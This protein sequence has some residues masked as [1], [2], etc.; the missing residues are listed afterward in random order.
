MSRPPLK[1]LTELF[2]YSQTFKREILTRKWMMQR[3]SERWET[4]MLQFSTPAVR[5]LALGIMSKERAQ[6]QLL[7]GDVYF[8]E[9]NG[10]PS[11]REH[12]DRIGEVMRQVIGRQ[13]T[14]SQFEMPAQ[15][16]KRYIAWSP[17]DSTS[18]GKAAFKAEAEGITYE[19]CI[20]NAE[21]EIA[22]IKQGKVT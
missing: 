5:K 15:D 17:S 20:A 3:S 14:E 22:T 11:I 6:Q 13:L 21:A 19:Q 9:Q 2:V 8:N 4:Y 18:V 1:A 12:W 16:G 7:K 10:S